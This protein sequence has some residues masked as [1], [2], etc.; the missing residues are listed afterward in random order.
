M[1]KTGVTHVSHQDKRVAKGRERKHSKDSQEAPLSLGATAV[2]AVLP[3]CVCWNLQ[4]GSR[5]PSVWVTTDWSHACL[6]LTHTSVQAP[7]RSRLVGC[8]PKVLLLN[9]AAQAIQVGFMETEQ[10][11]VHLLGC[12]CLSQEAD[13]HL[14]CKLCLSQTTCFA[15]FFLNLSI[16][17][18]FTLQ[19]K[20]QES[21]LG[22][23][24]DIQS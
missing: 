9:I 19:K 17:E 4:E 21:S 13:T 8:M 2:I 5:A 1:E 23:S 14:Y 18:L 16:L 20:M 3:Q 22:E 12:L 24:L 6:C 11:L 7:P 15:A 10:L